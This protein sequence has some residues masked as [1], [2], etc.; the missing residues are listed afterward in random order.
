[1]S[2][3]VPRVP[4]P[5]GLCLS[6]YWRRV[7]DGNTIEAILPLGGNFTLRIDGYDT[8]EKSSEN[9]LAAIHALEGLLEQ[10]TKCT[11][12]LNLPQESDHFPKFENT[13]IRGTLFADS[14]RVDLWMIEHGY[15]T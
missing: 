4:P 9:G 3:M 7:L 15:S 14:T 10:A 1:M 8:P 6:I 11:L 2:V 5:Y 12:W 13:T